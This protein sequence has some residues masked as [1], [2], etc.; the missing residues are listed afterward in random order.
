MRAFLAAAF[1][2]FGLLLIVLEGL[3]VP[4]AG[5]ALPFTARVLDD[6]RRVVISVSPAAAR[7]GIRV[8]DVFDWSIS[9][10][11]VRV[12][13][14]EDRRIGPWVVPVTRHGKYVPISVAIPPRTTQEQLAAYADI[15]MKFIGFAVGILLIARGRGA[16]G[17]FSGLFLTG[18]FAYEGFNTSLLILPEPWATLTY[19]LVLLIFCGAFLRY[20]AVEAMIAL[21]ADG[22]RAW[23]RTFFRCAQGLGCAL[24]VLPFVNVATYFGLL[25]VLHFPVNFYLIGQVIQLS[26]ILGYA[27]ALLRPATPEKGLIAWILWS[28]VLGFSGGYAGLASVLIWLTVPAYGA[29]NLT[30]IFMAFGYAYVALRYRIIDLSFVVNRALVY[31]IMLA[32]IVGGLIVTETLVTN[33]AIGG[34]KSIIIQIAVALA[35]GFSIKHLEERIDRVVERA[36]FAKK[37]AAEEGLRALMR[38]C[39]HVENPERLAANVSEEARRLIGAQHVVV[40][41]RSGDWLKPLASSPEI[42]PM[43]SVNIDDPVVVRMRSALMEIELGALRSTLG[44]EGIVFPMLARGRVVGVLVCG[45]KPGRQAYDPDERKLLFDLAHEAGTSLLLLRSGA[46]TPFSLDE[47]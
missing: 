44:S 20:F 40:Y 11:Q 36:F 3:S 15:P 39:A 37:F 5:G 17:F 42:V 6:D 46:V 33:F 13:R 26:F 32:V 21:C 30:I 16:F 2:V 24:M 7:A 9:P 28:S 38:D 25:P 18:M 47:A 43:M 8:G 19:D 35:L 31:G 41:E 10:P 1:A 34:E 4:V 23:E 14:Y 29:F 22:L 12:E 27:I 45:N